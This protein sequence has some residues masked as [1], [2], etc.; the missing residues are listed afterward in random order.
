[1]TIAVVTG[2]AGFIGSNLVRALL[3]RGD[4]VRVVDDLSTGRR[5]NIADIENK[6]EFY[7]TSICDCDALPPIFEGADVCYHQ[8]ALA[9]VPRSIADPTTTNHVNV[10]GT[11]NVFVAARD[12]GVRRVVYASSSSVYGDAETVPVEETYPLCPIS[13]YAVS[14]AANELYARNFFELYGIEMVGLRY[15][16]IFGPRQDPHSH[17]SAVI[18]IFVRRMLEGNPPIVH[19]DG[20][21]SRD[22]TYIENVVNANI[23]AADHKGT[24]SGVFNVACGRSTSLLTMIEYLNQ[25]MGSGFEPEYGPPRSGDI[26]TSFADISRAREAFGYEPAVHI[27]EGLRRTV[28]WYMEHQS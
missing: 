27:E 16:N 12:A 5:E 20:Q 25:A 9:S 6:I 11:L 28:A 22:F 7:Q 15:F 21:Q 13:P 18:P 19:G 24:L 8:A 26:T 4:A 17:Y 10:T 14:K 1:M 2:G 23:K 3:D